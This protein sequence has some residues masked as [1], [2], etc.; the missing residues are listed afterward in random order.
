MFAEWIKLIQN[1]L[2]MVEKKVKL[3]TLKKIIIL[4]LFFLIPTN[5]SLASL[6]FFSWSKIVHI[7]TFSGGRTVCHFQ[8]LMLYM[9]YEN[10][11]Y[12]HMYSY[13]NTL[14]LLLRSLYSFWV[15]L[16]GLPFTDFKRENIIKCSRKLKSLSSGWISHSNLFP[17][18]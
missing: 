2:K 8:L 6:H 14:Y 9:L 7:I 4:L 12:I 15:D 13:I 1:S 3:K 17:H 18:E 10:F 5:I 11:V 16:T